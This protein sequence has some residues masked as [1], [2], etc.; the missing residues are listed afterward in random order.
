[1]GVSDS[2]VHASAILTDPLLL[3]R[4]IDEKVC[5]IIRHL[6]TEPDGEPPPIPT[7]ETKI[8]K[9]TPMI[10]EMRWPCRSLSMVLVLACQ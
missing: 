6:A 7:L 9:K 5:C 2:D 1:M 8:L 10:S 4:L 3:L